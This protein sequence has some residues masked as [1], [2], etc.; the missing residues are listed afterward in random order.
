M[1]TQ[2]LV[3]HYYDELYFGTGIAAEGALEEGKR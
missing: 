2:P 3:I 1:L